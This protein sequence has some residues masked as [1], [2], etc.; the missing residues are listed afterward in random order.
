[1]L[2]VDVAPFD[3]AHFAR[4]PRVATMCVAE[5]WAADV[6]AGDDASD[7]ETC[8]RTLAGLARERAADGGETCGVLASHNGGAWARDDDVWTRFVLAF[9][10]Y[11]AP[12]FQVFDTADGVLSYTNKRPRLGQFVTLFGTDELATAR[13]LVCVSEYPRISAVPAGDAEK[14]AAVLKEFEA[15]LDAGKSDSLYCGD[16]DI[17]ACAARLANEAIQLPIVIDGKTYESGGGV[18]IYFKDSHELAA[19]APGDELDRALTTQAEVDEWL[20]WQ[21]TR[22]AIRPGPYKGET[23]VLYNSLKPMVRDDKKRKTKK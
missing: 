1:M 7:D 5:A 18:A 20:G 4:K 23:I 11:G 10:K 3:D 9:R 6:R 14:E 19:Y 21:R 13:G 12:L 8:L 2:A 22:G 17:Q 15:A 16:Y